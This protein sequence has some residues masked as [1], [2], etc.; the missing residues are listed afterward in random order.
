MVNFEKL[1][2]MQKK[3][4][5]QTE[6]SIL[7]LAGAGSGKT[8][9]LVSRILYLIQIGIEPSNILAI[10]F[11]NKAANEMK[12]RIKNIIDIKSNY[13]WIN[14]FHSMCIKILR[15]N[16]HSL[17]YLNSFSIYDTDDQEKLI[18]EI[19]KKL[20]FSIEKTF[21]IKS[22]LN[23]IS[24]LKNNLISPEEYKKCC[25]K[26]LIKN[27]IA[28][29]YI[30]YQKLLKEYNALDFDDIIYKTIQLFKLDYNILNYYQEKFK[31]IMVDEYQDTNFSQYELI[32]L[33]SGK[34]KNICVVGDD[35]QSIYG[36]RG[37]NIRNILDFEKDFKDTLIIKL[38]QNY[39]STKNILNAANS[40]ILNNKERKNKKLW[41]ENDSG[42]IINLFEALDEN[43][44]INYISNTIN[45][46]IKEKNKKFNDFVVL[47]RNNSQSNVIEKIFLKKNIPYRIF[48]GIRFFD[49]KEIKDI[50]AYL[51]LL[52]NP[53]D[54]VSF[55]RVINKP[56]RGIGDISIDKLENFAKQRNLSLFDSICYID[57]LPELK[58]KAKGFRNFYNILSDIK[59]KIFKEEISILDSN[60]KNPIKIS[61]II[62]DIIEKTNY[63]EN[64]EYNDKNDLDSR[65]ENIN[66]FITIAKEYENNN[67]KPTLK[68]FLEEI[69]LENNIDSYDG[70]NNY[71]TL[72]TL[73]TS[74]GLEFQY[75]FIIGLEENIFPSYNAI[76]YGNNKNIE[77]ERR[78]CYVGITRAKKQLFLSYCSSR[79]QNGIKT[80][81]SP[82]RFLDEIPSKFFSKKNLLLD[83][84]IGKISNLYNNSYYNNLRKN[85]NEIPAPK[86]IKLEFDIG[87]KVKVPKWGI[88]T[89]KSI[90]P[91]GADFEIGVSF[92]QK[93]LK[94]FM[95]SLSKLKKISEY[96]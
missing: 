42:N 86:N 34:H 87:D 83:K 29:I 62:I 73:H 61:S 82:S 4:V 53:Y 59:S 54:K 21:N 71:V 16:I 92:S 60:K 23:E 77:E 70:N 43:D 48:S 22:V 26:D 17:G 52:E 37:A 3:V 15:R 51:K 79:I 19:F 84:N 6:G 91:A 20:N 36:W 31:Y 44:E 12:E 41:T 75:V 68:G 8:G 11:T 18:R 69:S 76:N 66:E 56:K 7:V 38:E 94:K 5:L 25:D 63:I 50:I 65:I 35:D 57:D 33:L 93:G 80:K 13:L 27:K 67:I 64:L 2:D 40:V 39:R 78:L 30:I 14:T 72:M 9:A 81:N 89:V 28:D 1:N 49:R 74:K 32:K 90:N 46:L 45:Y 24:K 85:V 95:A 96:E 47:Y 58:Q 88:G 10:T 55:K